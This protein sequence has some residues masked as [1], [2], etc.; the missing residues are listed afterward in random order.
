MCKICQ[1]FAKFDQFFSGF[2][3]NAAIF[4]SCWRLKLNG[5][6]LVKIWILHTFNFRFEKHLIF[7]HLH[8]HSIFHLIFT[9]LSRPAAKVGLRLTRAHHGLRRPSLREWSARTRRDSRAVETSA[10]PEPVIAQMWRAAP[11]SPLQIQLQVD[12]VRSTL[13]KRIHQETSRISL[14]TRLLEQWDTRKSIYLCGEN[15]TKLNPKNDYDSWYADNIRW[16]HSNAAVPGQRATSICSI[17]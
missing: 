14:A 2:A 5:C 3:Q 12:T 11:P 13:Q 15:F 17:E 4:K 16:S 8:E 9:E 7:F 10:E 6:K 1:N